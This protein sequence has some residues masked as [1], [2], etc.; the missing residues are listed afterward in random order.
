MIYDG[1]IIDCD[2]HLYEPDVSIW[3]R[4]LPE[5]YRRDYSVR[6]EPQPDGH[7]AMFVGARR[8]AL[9]DAH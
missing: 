5:Q 1:P 3:N 6:M 9:G 4:H 7:M 2:A 8:L